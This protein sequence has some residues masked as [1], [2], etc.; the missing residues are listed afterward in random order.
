MKI[1]LA[2][3]NPVVGDVSGN[4]QKVVATLEQE[5]HAADLVVFSELFLVGY[6]PRDL[7]EKPALLHKVEEALE[8]LVALSAR[9]PDTG[10]LVGAPQPTGRDTGKGLC[11]C[12]VLIHQG[13]VRLRQA[14]S[15]LPTYDV[16]DETRH[17]DPAKEVK[18]IPFKDE[19]LG[20]SICEDA[21][22][23]PELWFRR[24]YSLDPIQV[25]ARQGATVL[26]NISASPFQVDKEEL[27]HRLL[28]AHTRKYG[29]P[30]VYVNQV[31]GNDELIF[32]GH[33]LAL[34]PAGEAL[35]V[36]PGFREVVTTVDL[37]QPG[38]PGR[39]SPMTPIAMVHE[40]LILGL[41]DYLRKCGFSKAVV[42]LSGG[43]DS[44]V[45][46]CLAQEALGREN[47][48]GVL[49]P[50]PYTSRDSIEDS[51]SLARNLG[52]EVK[53]IPI[54][55]IYQSYREALQEPLE[56]GEIEVTLENIQA[57]IRG[58]ILMAISNKYGHMVLST[59][60]KSELA[61]GYCTLYGDMSGGLSVLADVPKTMVY[62]LA[63]YLNRDREVIPPQIIHKAPSAELRPDQKDQDSLPPY[64]ILDR[65][66]NYYLT[67]GYAYGEIVE[68]GFDPE[69]VKWVIR[70]I[71]RNEYKRRQAAPGLKITSKAFGM[72][73]RIPIAARHEF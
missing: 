17:F 3:L 21:W 30:L 73:R 19:I 16:F 66:M 20:I 2:Q 68:L 38:I 14:K 48:M 47:V 6:P 11:N 40:A 69:T 34:D 1:T 46:C 72:G 37:A 59:G 4:L 65:I 57:R 45:T 56:L 50:S 26:I 9:Y 10:L 36:L 41:K 43:V 55:P 13:Q 35:A 44:A 29:I 58:N 70:T 39:Y 54:T 49:M 62:E 42:G 52:V 22:Y 25:Q 63:H 60:N 51:L 53:L 64:D 24:L 12:A 31:G 5:G 28:Q 8:H 61:V 33:S 7:L 71:D 23:E 15:L 18:V 32:D 27:R 67:E